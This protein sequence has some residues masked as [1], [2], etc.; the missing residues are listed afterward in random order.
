MYSCCP[1]ISH[2]VAPVQSVPQS[3]ARAGRL[4]FRVVY[5]ASVIVVDWTLSQSLVE[6]LL[7]ELVC[8]RQ[9]CLSSICECV[10]DDY[11][12]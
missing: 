10:A 1:T 7:E 6:I 5:S 12:M 2:K 3:D 9:D 4:R 8:T 11:N